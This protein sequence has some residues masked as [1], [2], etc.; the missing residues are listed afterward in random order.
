ML[1]SGPVDT[2]SRPPSI[3]GHEAMTEI[4]LSGGTTDLR[5]VIRAA[6]GLHSQTE[7]NANGIKST[8]SRHRGKI[9]EAVPPGEAGPRCAYGDPLA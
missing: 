1:A 5:R 6:D 7:I 8:S 4:S 2:A 3:F 9:R